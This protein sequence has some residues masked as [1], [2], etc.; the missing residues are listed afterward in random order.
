VVSHRATQDIG[1]GTLVE[2]KQSGVPKMAFL[3]A[4]VEVEIPGFNSTALRERSAGFSAL[5]PIDVH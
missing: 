5:P 1:F 2:A 3:S 4:S